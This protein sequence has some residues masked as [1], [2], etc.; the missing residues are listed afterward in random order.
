MKHLIMTSLL[1]LSACQQ[2]IKVNEVTTQLSIIQPASPT[3]ITITEPNWLVVTTGNEADV[4]KENNTLIAV[5]PNDFN[6]IL[7]GLNDTERYIKQQD[8]IISYYQNALKSQQKVDAK[9]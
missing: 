1:V 2:P 3:P 6:N 7:L 9:P 8:E 4:L 5:T